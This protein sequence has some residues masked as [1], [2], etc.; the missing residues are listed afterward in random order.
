M[1]AAGVAR[2]RPSKVRKHSGRTRRARSSRLTNT[3][4][5]VPTGPPLQYGGIDGIGVTTGP[6]K[7]YVVFWG[8][9]WGT[10][11]PPGS[12][13]FSRDPWRYTD[14]PTSTGS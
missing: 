6:E 13:N 5:L 1:Q 3:A 12:T 7:V 8:S 14:A 11:N 4:A 2:T 9:Q 10:A